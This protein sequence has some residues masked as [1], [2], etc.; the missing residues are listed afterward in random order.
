MQ[1]QASPPG[2]GPAGRSARLPRASRVADYAVMTL[3]VVLGAGSLPLLGL[4][5]RPPL[6]PLGM[7]PA[8]ALWWDAFLSL[9]F[10]TQHSVMVRRP[11]RARLASVVPPRY[12]AAFYAITSGAALALFAVFYQ[13]VESPVLFAATGTAL[14]AVEAAIVLAF[15]VFV[16]AA[17]AIPAFDPLGLRPI[18]R[19][20]REGP[21]S[22]AAASSAETFVVRG[23]FRWVRHPMYSACIV[24]LWAAPRMTADRLE[25]AVL[26]TTWI[27]VGTAF[28]E[29]DLLAEFGETYRQYRKRVPMFV[30][31]RRPAPR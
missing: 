5:T 26:W 20:L 8:A 24:L 29:R 25:L 30:P 14:V 1:A 15:C 16:W 7:T 6:V 21:A 13:R 17:A 19:H 23:P 11:V 27:V 18:Q 22:P 3:A 12:D 2:A 28:E 31:W 4:L 9:L 10:F